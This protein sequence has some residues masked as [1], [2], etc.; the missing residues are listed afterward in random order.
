MFLPDF[1]FYFIFL[2]RT[3]DNRLVL[4][5]FEIETL[6]GVEFNFDTAGFTDYFFNKILNSITA[7]LTGVVR[8]LLSFAL[9]VFIGVKLDEINDKI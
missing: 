9:T 3:R 2:S 1:C 6:E 8:Y 7:T 5:R 4:N